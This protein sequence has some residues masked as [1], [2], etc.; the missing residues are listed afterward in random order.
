[1]PAPEDLS[2]S[3]RR[4]VASSLKTGG[5]H[6]AQRDSRRAQWRSLSVILVFLCASVACA[7]APEKFE[8]SGSAPTAVSDAADSARRVIAAFYAWYLPGALTP[9]ST[10]RAWYRVLDE[11][12]A[13]LS[14]SLFKALT[15][16]REAQRTAPDVIAGLD[17]DPFL[18]SQ[19]PCTA[20]SVVSATQSGA[21]VIVVIQPTCAGDREPQ[22]PFKAIMIRHDRAWVVADFEYP[23]EFGG[24]LMNRL[25]R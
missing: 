3:P 10:Q 6:G 17:G 11:R 16:D 23:G 18:N 5:G 13:V 22:S 20:Y 24:T 14:D 7:P 15:R 1:M 25:R 12:P 19:D 21:Q 2:R 4:G 8:A 9:T